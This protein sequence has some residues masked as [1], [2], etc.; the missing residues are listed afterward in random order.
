MKTFLLRLVTFAAGVIAGGY[1]Y[2]QTDLFLYILGG[3]LV[4]FIVGI[5]VL[6]TKSFYRV[7]ELRAV[8]AKYQTLRQKH[9]SQD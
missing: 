7:N 9:G 6:V 8:H 1:Y 4:V 2:S 3:I 5:I